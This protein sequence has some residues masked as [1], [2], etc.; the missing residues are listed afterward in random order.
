MLRE[1]QGYNHNWVLV[2]IP[3]LGSILL[4]VE[5]LTDPGLSSQKMTD[6]RPN[7]LISRKVDTDLQMYITSVM[8]DVRLESTGGGDLSEGPKEA[9]WY[10]STDG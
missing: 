3:G 1:T 4:V 2:W 6:I 5:K 9:Q 10:S 8:F 7:S